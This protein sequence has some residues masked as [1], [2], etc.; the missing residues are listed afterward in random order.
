MDPFVLVEYHPIWILYEKRPTD[1]QTHIKKEEK[2][3][4]QCN[5]CNSTGAAIKIRAEN[6]NNIHTKWLQIKFI[7]IFLKHSSHSLMKQRQH[8]S[9]PAQTQAHTHFYIHSSRSTSQC[10][11]SFRKY[12][13][14]LFNHVHVLLW[15]IVKLFICYDEPMVGDVCGVH[16]YE[17]CSLVSF[18][19]HGSLSFVS[20]NMFYDQRWQKLYVILLNDRTDALFFSLFF[21]LSSPLKDVNLWKIYRFNIMDSMVNFAILIRNDVWL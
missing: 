4:I 15:S 7:H 6:C 21:P 13:I 14:N 1:R 11:K 8:P 19:S 12:V 5:L 2:I 9:T 18:Y 10:K 3:K 20:T 16:A 17:W